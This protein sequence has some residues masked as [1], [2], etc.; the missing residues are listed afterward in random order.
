MDNEII[1]AIKDN[2]D[3][4]MEDLAE[5]LTTGDYPT[6]DSDPVHQWCADNGVTDANPELWAG[7]SSDPIDPTSY[8]TLR[9]TL[10][11]VEAARFARRTNEE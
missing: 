10:T 5:L 6:L 3:P 11:P 8:P 9:L 7:V 1:L 4:T 2:P